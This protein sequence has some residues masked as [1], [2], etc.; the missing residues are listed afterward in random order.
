MFSCVNSFILYVRSP[1]FIAHS[2]PAFLQMDPDSYTARSSPTISISVSYRVSPRP[3]SGIDLQATLLSLAMTDEK[4]QVVSVMQQEQRPVDGE[5]FDLSAPTAT[6][7]APRVK[8]E[9]VMKRLFSHEHLH[10]ILADHILF[11]RFSSFLNRYKVCEFQKLRVSVA[12]T[13]Q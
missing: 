9:D 13:N 1:E 5:F 2:L 11:Y 7:E 3:I 10:F 8:L 12:S 6:N 4:P